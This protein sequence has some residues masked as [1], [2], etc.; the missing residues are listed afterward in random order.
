[1]LHF[2]V[3]SAVLFGFTVISDFFGSE[4]SRI[5]RSHWK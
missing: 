5:N 3:V 2:V 1:M 4:L